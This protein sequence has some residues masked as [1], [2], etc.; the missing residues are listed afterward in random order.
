MKIHVMCG[1]LYVI[2]QL[3]ILKSVSDIRMA[4]MTNSMITSLF[5]MILRPRKMT[6]KSAIVFFRS[7]TI[8]KTPNGYTSVTDS[9]ITNSSA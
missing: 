6:M 2:G 1:Y 4:M 9:R 3:D 7:E 8:L 5:F